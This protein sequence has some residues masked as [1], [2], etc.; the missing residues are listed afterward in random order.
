MEASSRKI[1]F[2]SLSATLLTMAVVYYS[3]Y[4]A[5]DIAKRYTPLVNAIMEIRL[6]ATTAHLWFEKIIS[7]DQTLN[8]EDIWSNLDQSE[9]YAQA[10]L[11]GGT[12]KEE[13]FLPLNDP[14]LRIQIKETINGIHHFRQIA[15]KRWASK[16]TSGI[17]SN[18][19]QQFDHAFLQFKLSTDNVEMA[20]QEAIT[21]NL[22]AFEFSQRLLMMIIL[23]WGIIISVLLLRY[24]TRRT[25]NID[26]LK[27]NEENI[28]KFQNQLLNVINGA[29]LGYWDW[30]Y[31]TGAHFVN[32]EWLSMLGLS[33]QDI[34]NHVRDWDSLIHPNDKM[35]MQR[36]VQN[37]IQ[38]GT[39]YVAEFR[40]MHTD[41]R[42]IWIQGSGAVVEYD[43]HTHEPLRLCGTHQ[44]ITDRKQSEEKLKLAASVF[45]HARE[46]I[47]ITDAKGTIIDLNDTF[48]KI[49]GYSREEAIGQNPRIL[50]SDRQSPQFYIDMWKALQEEGYWYGEIWNRRKNGEVYAQMKTISA[51]R[52]EHGVTSHYVALGNIPNDNN[53]IR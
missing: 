9:W 28:R 7:G 25:K 11:D 44:N 6:E 29:K 8:I 2:L 34:T 23:T 43:K 36:V 46:D 48:T 50:Q 4:T 52:D 16:S 41:G 12:N 45:T 19:D 13:S 39:N 53:L 27:L 1:L 22:Q 51:V 3:F 35:L 26:V 21:E 47:I 30:N 42:W 20:L 32:D 38:S 31:K 10:M 49:T 5:R 37:H 24:N 14:N 17:G 33:R 18:I 40:M 15:Q